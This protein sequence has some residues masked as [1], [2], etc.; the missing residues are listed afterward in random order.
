MDWCLGF[1]LFRIDVV[2]CMSC[3]GSCL[4]ELG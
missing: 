2:L 4:M 3:S 1:W